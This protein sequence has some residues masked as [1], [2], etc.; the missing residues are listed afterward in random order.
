VQKD[1]HQMQNL[2]AGTRLLAHDRMR[3]VMR[4]KNPELHKLV[5]GLQGRMETLLKASGG[6]PKLAGRE[7]EGARFAL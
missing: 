3:P 7:P 2:L 6:D 1:P 5:D 4:I